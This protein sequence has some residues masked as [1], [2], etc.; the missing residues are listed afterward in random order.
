MQAA[1]WRPRWQVTRH[2][3]ND[4][5]AHGH[6]SVYGSPGA[7]GEPQLSAQQEADKAA[8]ATEERRRVRSR[9]TAWRAATETRQAHL[10]RLLAGA[11]LPKAM[12]EAA[13]RLRAGAIA[14][15]ETEPSMTSFGHQTAG[16][17][18]ALKSGDGTGYG[19]REAL[20]ALTEAAAVNRVAVVELA[21]ILGAAEHGCA[22]VQT[23][24]DAES[25]HYGYR[26]GPSRSI[27]Y[28][29]WLRDHASYGLSEIEAEV[30]ELGTPKP[31]TEEAAGAGPA[32]IAPAISQVDTGGGIPAPAGDGDREP[33]ADAEDALDRAHGLEPGPDNPA[34]PDDGRGIGVRPEDWEFD[35][36]GNPADPDLEAAEAELAAAAADAIGRD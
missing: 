19:A 3:C 12:T 13:A 34:D 30:V 8:Q 18:L 33:Y 17:L 32:D 4:P 25:P 36:D 29:T 16:E 26:T 9:N 5:D 10:K 23:W 24:K 22:D 6:V 27:R 20:I 2:L 15:G 7:G 1:G 11:R 21:M 31:K 14:R 35:D 28:L